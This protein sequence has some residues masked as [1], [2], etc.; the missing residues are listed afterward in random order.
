MA[1]QLTYLLAPSFRFKPGTGPIALGNIIADPL[2]PHRALTTVEAETLKREYPRV[3]TITDH[4]RNMTRSN[5]LNFSTAV[6]SQFLQKI[7]AKMSCERGANL[8][9][10]YTMGALETAYFVT[11]PPLDVI[12]MRLKAPRV[13]A[14]IKSSSIP[15]FRHPVYMVTGLMVARGF[16]VVQERG[17]IRACEVAVGGH[18]ASPTGDIGLGANTASSSIAR[19]SDMWRT[20]E[21]I[22]FA[23]QLLKIEIKGWRGTRIEFD[24]LRH[25]AAYLSKDDSDLDSESDG[26]D[27]EDEIKGQVT[28]CVAGVDNL[29]LSSLEEINLVEVEGSKHGITCI[30]AADG[31]DY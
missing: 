23:Y 14:V 5:S 25:K 22:V 19:E 2:R 24:E 30:S 17:K 13:Q 26:E 7:S 31:K 16:A 28:V 27:T 21:D 1:Q 4:N 3:E 10:A 20:G 9:T 11:D 29:P 6:W 8:Q 12:E 15:G 18:I